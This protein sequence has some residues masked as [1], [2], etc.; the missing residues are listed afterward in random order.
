MKT[1]VKINLLCSAID[2]VG[3]I[4]DLIDDPREGF[5][6]T[7]ALTPSESLGL[8][9][10]VSIV[11]ELWGELPDAILA[12]C[13]DDEI[14]LIGNWYK[15]HDSINDGDDNFDLDSFRDKYFKAHEV[16]YRLYNEAQAYLD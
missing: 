14:A 1:V 2:V 10:S 8:A 12:R 15:H 3:N 9:Q 6:A 4:K 11:R 5:A 7:V 13:S 16:I